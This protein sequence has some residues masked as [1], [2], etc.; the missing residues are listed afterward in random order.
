MIASMLLQDLRVKCEVYVEFLP[1]QVFEHFFQQ[2]CNLRNVEFIG[3][4][5]WIVHADIL[6]VFQNN[7]LSQCEVFVLNNTASE[8]MHLGMMTVHLLLEKCPKLVGLG[9]LKTWRKI[10]YFDP[11]SDFFYKTDSMFMKLKKEAIER[12][13]EIDFDLETIPKL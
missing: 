10:D 11:E 5:D 1:E 12:N 7:S 2:C 13:W 6:D 9:D 3:P 8:M 4:I